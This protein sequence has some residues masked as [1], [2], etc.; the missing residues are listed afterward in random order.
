MPKKK[1][2]APSEPKRRVKIHRK[3]AAPPIDPA[4]VYAIA[5]A[6]EAQGIEALR[7]A[8]VKHEAQM[9]TLRVILFD[10][11]IIY[12]EE[13]YKASD[14]VTKKR[15]ATHIRKIRNTLEQNVMELRKFH[16]DPGDIDDLDAAASVDL[17]E[18]GFT[19]ENGV[20]IDVAALIRQVGDNAVDAG[21][22]EAGAVP[23]IL[24]EVGDLMDEMLER[25]SEETDET[26]DA[27]GNGP[28][29]HPRTQSRAPR[30]RPRR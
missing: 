30:G 1:K 24:G 17:D 28:R 5:Q 9:H 10:M 15:F 2:T 3:G 7:Q 16:D 11:L 26:D 12:R 25:A 13:H 29:R 6:V 27:G 22:I 23:N 21:E 18:E 14:V 20:P 8:V 4:I 19:D